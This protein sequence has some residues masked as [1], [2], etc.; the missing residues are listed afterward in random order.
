MHRDALDLLHE[1][2]LLAGDEREHVRVYAREQRE[3]GHERRERGFD[4]TTDAARVDGVRT[5]ECDP[6]YAGGK[7]GAD[8]NVALTDPA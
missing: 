1:D 7:A 3:P 8:T 5:D 4:A 6:H 2:A